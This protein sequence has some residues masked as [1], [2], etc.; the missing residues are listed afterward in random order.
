MVLIDL[1]K[2]LSTLGLVSSIAKPI[3]VIGGV[4]SGLLDT[5]GEVVNSTAGS[6]SGALNGILGSGGLI[7]AANVT[8]NSTYLTA[9]Y[10]DTSS[11]GSDNSTVTTASAPSC[12]VTP[13]TP[14]GDITLQPFAPYDANKALIYRYRQQQ[15]V[16]LGSWFVLEQWMTPSLFAGCAAGNAQAELDVAMGWGSVDGARQVLERHWDEWIQES[17]FQY[18]ASIGELGRA[19]WVKLMGSGINTV[20]IPIG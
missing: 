20:R 9:S 5:A 4:A 11:S 6:S 18:L 19:S 8:G 13:Y 1:Q 15:S 10:T 7:A 16:N 3:P 14:P 17:D 2:V 12:A